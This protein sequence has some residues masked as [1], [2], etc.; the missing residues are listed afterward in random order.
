MCGVVVI[1]LLT[2]TLFTL[3]FLE[4]FFKLLNDSFDWWY[5]L[6]AVLLL[7]PFFIGVCFN[8][9]WMSEDTNSS[10]AKL[11]VSC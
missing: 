10:R 6:V 2:T 5:V 3:L 1:S 9:S 8:I 11:W 4:V 7:V